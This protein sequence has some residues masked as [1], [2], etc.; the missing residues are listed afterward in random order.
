MARI[1]A[2][3]AVH[4]NTHRSPR[5]NA[6]AV[7][8]PTGRRAV[9]FDQSMSYAP[10]ARSAPESPADMA[11]DCSRRSS[12]TTRLSN[13]RCS[14]TFFGLWSRHRARRAVSD[15]KLLR[16]WGI[17]LLSGVTEAE[18]HRWTGGLVLMMPGESVASDEFENSFSPLVCD[19]AVHS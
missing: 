4:C 11:A 1:A 12:A 13:P 17:V 5:R 2:C 7:S 10:E 3:H 16:L 19:V 14:F 9:S 6:D 15:Q 8:L 18:L